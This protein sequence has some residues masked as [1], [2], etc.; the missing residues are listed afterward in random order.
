MLMPEVTGS[1]SVFDEDGLNKRAA[2]TDE[3]RGRGSRA[4]LPSMY[5]IAALPWVALAPAFYLRWLPWWYGPPLAVVLAITERL[6]E[7][8]GKHDD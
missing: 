6:A 2:R 5:L 3:R 4:A 7:L 1:E 8:K